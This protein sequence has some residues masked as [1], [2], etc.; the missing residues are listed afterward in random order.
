MDHRRRAAAGKCPL[1]VAHLTEVVE[2]HK[3]GIAD[4]PRDTEALLLVIE[5]RHARPLRSADVHMHMHGVLRRAA[6]IDHHSGHRPGD[7]EPAVPHHE[8]AV[9]PN[10]L[11]RQPKDPF[12]VAF[13]D[14]KRHRRYADPEIPKERYLVG[15]EHPREPIADQSRRVLERRSLPV[16]LDTSRCQSEKCRYQFAELGIE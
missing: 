14:G 1:E 7:I 3:T 12:I 11:P 6:R 15:R 13:D 10:Q 16:V 2:R 5:R 8:R 9:D 4:R